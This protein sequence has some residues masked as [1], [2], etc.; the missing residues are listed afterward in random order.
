MMSSESLL[1]ATESQSATQMRDN[2]SSY[3]ILKRRQFIQSMGFAGLA[4]PLTGIG[5]GEPQAAYPHPA[6]PSHRKI[7]VFSKTL[8]W[9][10]LEQMADMVA[11]C[12]CDGLDLTVRPGGHIEPVAAR[13]Q[14]PHFA[15]VLRKVGREIVMLSTAIDS[16]DDPYAEAILATAGSLGIKH[17]RTGY[18][19][20]DHDRSIETNL[21]DFAEKLSSMI[22]LNAANQIQACYQNHAGVRMGA[23]VWD[24]GVVLRRVESSWVGAQYD[25]RHAMV[26]GANAWSLGFD[27]VR[28][29]INSF[30]FK[31]FHWQEEGG[32]GGP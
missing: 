28:P 26:E 5:A 17:Y 24:L 19:A 4:A 29:Y 30:I 14:L 11:A 25:I 20:Y 22:P 31:D 8:Q 13:D 12:D 15:E 2:T 21:E 23:P 18:H 9:T 32:R 6:A 3:C 27:Y 16:A 10:E 1:P 7:A